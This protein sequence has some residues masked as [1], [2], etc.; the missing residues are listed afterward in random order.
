[1]RAADEKEACVRAVEHGQLSR[2]D[3]KLRAARAAF[4]TCA[5]PVCPDAIR[6]DCTR[7]VTEVD[8][9]LP[10]VVID[11]VWADGRD[12][13]GM[14]V[15]LDGQPLA[16]ADGGRAVALD[17]G[18]HAF[19]FEVAG[20]APVDARHVIREGEKNRILLVTFNARIP[21]TLVP[22]APS[23]T[24]APAGLWRVPG[25]EDGRKPAAT[26]ASLP[27]APLVLG[28]VGLL[29]FGGFAYFGLSGTSQLD[30]MRF[31][32]RA[33]V[34][35]VGRDERAERDPR[36]RHPG[37]RRPGSDRRRR[38]ALLGS[39]RRAPPGDADAVGHPA[40]QVVRR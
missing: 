1:M 28:G 38:L 33:R 27:I 18:E 6:E 35:S 9:S 16:G 22:P 34:Q 37:L 15:L 19:R 11:A 32:V 30:S 3:G 36:R 8:A 26:R 17:P 5:R 2:L 40:V 24:S 29:G 4:V 7:W 25:A 12:V 21:S 39:P 13:T 14:T 31:D 10:S 23:A 20:A